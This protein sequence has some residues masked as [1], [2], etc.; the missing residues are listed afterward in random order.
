VTGPPERLG[1][2][3]FGAACGDLARRVAA[4]GYRPDAVLAVARGG[5]LPAGA[6]AYALGVKRVFLVN[7]EFYTGVDARLP[8][9]VLLP[10]ELR[11]SD[12]ADARLLVVDDIADTG[13][14][15]RLVRDLCRDDAGAVRTAVLYEKPRSVIR[16]D[17]AWRRTDRWVEFPW[18]ARAAGG[19]TPGGA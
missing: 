10:P 4:D 14:T 11:T 15:L 2:D 8:A 6:L 17:Y 9:P 18:S 3:G 7:V 16:P 12:L 13:A 19:G 5:L 1:W